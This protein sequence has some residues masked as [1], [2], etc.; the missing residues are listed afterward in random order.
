MTTTLTSRVTYDYLPTGLPPSLVNGAA[1]ARLLGRDRHD[2]ALPWRGL[3]LDSART[4]WT[5]DAVLEV[6][7]LMHRYGFNRLHWHLTDNSGWRLDVPGYPRLTEVAAQQPRHGFAEYTNVP[8]QD[9]RR[10]Q[11]RAPFLNN[12]GFYTAQ[13]VARVVE[14]AAE[15]GIEVVPEIDVPGHAEATIKA[16]PELGNPSTVGLDLSHWPGAGRARVRNDLL[17]PCEEAFDFITAALETV[18]DLFPSPIIHVGGD[19]CDVEYWESNPEARAWMEAHGV[20]DGHALQ[21]VFMRHARQV[22]ASRGRRAGVWD[23]AVEAGLDGDE[24]VF[25]WREGKGVSTA[26]ASGHPWVF[27]D[28]DL[29]YLNRLADPDPRRDTARPVTMN[30]AISVEDILGLILPEDERLQ[31]IQAAVW[32]E[33]I[34]DRAELHRQLFPRL[35]AVAAKAFWGREADAS[36]LRELVQ[37]ES[38]VLARAGYGTDLPQPT[39]PHS[40]SLMLKD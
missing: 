20:P 40:P 17:W 37:R 38:V 28:A 30:G 5:V 23:E 33:F 15:L 13:D 3:L 21:Q 35:L 18:C 19:E 11:A 31:G 25:G 16:Y 12:C 1:S 39:A 4:F 7:E 26:R 32:C 24:L 36:V 34:T 10:Y 8:P 9:L 29:L 22:L 6:L 14:R 27:C 2:P